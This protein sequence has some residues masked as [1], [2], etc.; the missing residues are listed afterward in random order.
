MVEITFKVVVMTHLVV[1]IT[2][3]VTYNIFLGADIRLLVAK[4]L[5]FEAVEITF[6]G[7]VISSSVTQIS[8][9]V[10]KIP[11]VVAEMILKDQNPLP[12]TEI[13]F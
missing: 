1:K 7:A 8:L 4:I 3:V 9:F 13:T 2:F 5:P 11:L 10:A 12:V 6:I